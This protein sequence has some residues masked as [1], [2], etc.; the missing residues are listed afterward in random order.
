MQIQDADTSRLQS[1][2]QRL[3][4]PNSPSGNPFTN[5]ATIEG[6]AVD[7]SFAN[8]PAQAPV[9]RKGVARLSVNVNLD[10]PTD[11]RMR[12]FVS[13]ADAVHQPT[14]LNIV[15]QK[16]SQIATVRFLA[17]LLVV[18]VAWRMRKSAVLWKLTVA[19]VLLLSSVAMLP[20]VA[21]TWQ[22]V[23]DGVAIGSVVSVLMAIICGCMSCCSC[24]LRWFRRKSVSVS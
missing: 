14:V 5:G 3:S 15:I 19:I 2:Q 7:A 18:I 24:S 8:Q 4:I 9:P 16:Q 20:L 17:V 22:S 10:I 11:Y 6:G 21:N 23:L 1:D 12:E 13:V